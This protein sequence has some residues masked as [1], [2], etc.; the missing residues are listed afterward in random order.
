MQASQV[1][2]GPGT[3]LAVATAQIWQ[4]SFLSTS[5]TRNPVSTRARATVV[6]EVRFVCREVARA[7]G[8]ADDVLELYSHV[9]T[10]FG[11]EA[12]LNGLPHDR[13]GGALRGACLSLYAGREACRNLE[14]FDDHAWVILWRITRRQGLWQL[15]HPEG[16]KLGQRHV[17]PQAP[18]LSRKALTVFLIS[19]ATV[20]GPTPP[21]TGDIFE[22]TAATALKSTSPTRR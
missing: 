8:A 19:M 15:R 12:A 2:Q 18:A 22:A 9:E 11:P 5:A 20:M 10:G 3:A 16:P 7:T 14:S 1:S 21:G 17:D 6:I 13:G 4:E